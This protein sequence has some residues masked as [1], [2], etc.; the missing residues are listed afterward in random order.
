VGQALLNLL[1]YLAEP[2]VPVSAYP[3]CIQASTRDEAF[4][5][6][7]SW[8]PVAVNVWIS[9]TAF[10][11]QLVLLSSDPEARGQALGQSELAV[12]WF[13]CLTTSCSCCIRSY[14]APG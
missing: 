5:V 9:V 14:P 2:V 12:Y 3:L 8:S 10:L 7:D 6:L 13:S 11:H 1:D 4:E